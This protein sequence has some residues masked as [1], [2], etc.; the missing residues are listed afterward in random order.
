PPALSATP[1]CVAPLPLPVATPLPTES[2]RQLHQ[3]R[4]KDLQ[5][6]RIAQE[7]V[8]AIGVCPAHCWCPIRRLRKGWDKKLLPLQ[9]NSLRP[10][11]VP[12]PRHVRP[13]VR[14]RLREQSAA[15]VGY[16][17]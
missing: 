11:L 12:Q 3:Y 10:A 7:L 1:P 9:D 6:L 8:C 13:V 17:C 15:G 4:K 2:G 16:R 5:N 14:T